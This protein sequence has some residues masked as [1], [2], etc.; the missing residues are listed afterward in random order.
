[1]LETLNFELTPKVLLQSLQ[2][3]KEELDLKGR[4][5]KKDTLEGKN[6]QEKQKK[7]VKK[8]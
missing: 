3:L 4:R 2:S 1:M 6:V 8:E 5:D 7:E